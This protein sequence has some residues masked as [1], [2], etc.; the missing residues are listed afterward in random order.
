MLDGGNGNRMTLSFIDHLEARLRDDPPKQKGQRT[1]ERLKIATA[2]VLE[3]KGYHAM[4]VTD[5]TETAQVAEGSFYVY[6]KD[7][8]EA[9]LT[10]LT[11]LLEDFFPIHIDPPRE[12]SAFES[13]Q[14]ANRRW[15]ALC[16][17]NPGLVRCI[18]QLGDQAPEFARLAQ[19]TNSAWYLRVTASVLRH[20][21]GLNDGAVMLMVQLLGAMMDEV[22]RKLIVYP[23]P[24]F[25]ALTERLGTGDDQ[26][27]DAASVIWLRVLYP[28]A[29]MPD[30][31]AD[32][33]AL[34][35]WVFGRSPAND[36]GGPDPISI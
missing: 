33:K 11:S 4:R 18:L 20:R 27:A 14:F 23:D 35:A 16:R 32:V 8:T 36:S 5:V 26:V 12:R 28:D 2:K 24:D 29:T 3:Q 34:S 7:K 25:V 19:R 21:E 9:A 6:F 31:P 13:I 15:L 22:V 17:A 1:R 30:L 10:V